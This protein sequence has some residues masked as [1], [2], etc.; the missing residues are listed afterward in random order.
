MSDGPLHGIRILD[1]TQGVTGPYATKL[2]SDF[3]AEVL[4]IEHPDRGDLSRRMGPF[5]GDIPHRETSGMFMELNSGKQSVTLNLKTRTGQE[6]LRRLA[7]TADVVIESFR[8]GVAAA[9][10]L[11]DD[12]LTTVNPQASYIHV[13]NFGQN[14]P[15]RDLEADD[16]LEYALSGILA[17]TAEFTREPVK[18]GLYA[19][20]FLAGGVVAAFT[21]GAFNGARRSGAGEHV[22]FSIHEMLTTSMD[23]GGPNLMAYQFSGSLM[24]ERQESS[25]TTALPTGVY[26]CAD[27]YVTMLISPNWWDRF[28]RMLG[29]PELITDPAM[30][31]NLLSLDFAVE[32]DGL[33]YPWLLE[34]TKQQ[35]MEA[36]QAEGIPISA[37]NNAADVARDPALLARGFWTP[38]EH[39]V[40]GTVTMPGLP[41]RMLGTPGELR[42]APL[43]GE[44]TFE[45]LTQRLGYAPED[46]ARLR[47]SNII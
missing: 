9:L 7:S 38:I 10:G 11:S 37:I 46:V 14:G 17:V 25:R 15:Y 20:L 43:L 34:R 19:P 18:I 13:S 23:R 4:K 35:V 42:R 12:D 45:V 21:F 27:G 44:H 33:V 47:Q 41:F 22:D 1:L 26:P 30:T 39:P 32:V 6:L 24:F 40:A 2:F 31:A 36:G 29:R 8:P 5:P 16:L 3:G 28:C